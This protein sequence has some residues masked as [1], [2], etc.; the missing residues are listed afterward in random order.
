MLRPLPPELSVGRGAEPLRDPPERWPRAF[1]SQ[2]RAWPSWLLRG[3]ARANSS[4][5]T[6]TRCIAARR[7]GTWVVLPELMY[8]ERA[9]GCWS[10]TFTAGAG[11]WR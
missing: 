8:K 2:P 6:G 10:I 3:R 5:S 9:R 1:W 11:G 7:A 4:R